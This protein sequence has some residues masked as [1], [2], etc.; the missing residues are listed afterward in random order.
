M[1]E[2]VAAYCEVEPLRQDELGILNWLIAGRIVLNVV[3]TAWFRMQQSSGSHF[4]GFDADYFGW[5]IEFAQRLVSQSNWPI[6]SVNVR[7]CFI[8]R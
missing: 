6:E 3:L 2:F 8:H 5:R 4:D 1:R 7:S